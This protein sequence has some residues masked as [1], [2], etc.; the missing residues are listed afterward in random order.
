[1][2]NVGPTIRLIRSRHHSAS[3]AHVFLVLGG[4]LADLHCLYSGILLG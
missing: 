4:E 3:D 1:M 2:F